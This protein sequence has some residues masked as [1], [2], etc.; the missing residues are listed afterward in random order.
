MD[1]IE[2]GDI[3][4]VKKQHPCGSLEWEVLRVGAD[5]RIKCQGCGHILMLPRPKVCTMIKKISRT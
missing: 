4:T 3:I 1:K 2:V 5:I